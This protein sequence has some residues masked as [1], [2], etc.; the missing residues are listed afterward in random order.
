MRP[1]ESYCS[2]IIERIHRYC[3]AMAV[4]ILFFN[5]KN[6]QR[7]QLIYRSSCI[8]TSHSRALGL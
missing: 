6:Y 3:A 2:K 7:L 8:S 4:H 5:L 1:L